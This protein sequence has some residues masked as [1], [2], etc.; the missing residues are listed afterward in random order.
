MEEKHTVAQALPSRLDTLLQ[1]K[2]DIGALLPIIYHIGKNE[3]WEYILELGTGYGRSTSV[4]AEIIPDGGFLITVDQKFY[5]KYVSPIK[6]IKYTLAVL[7][8]DD[9]RVKDF[10]KKL[11]IDKIDCL[12]IDADHRANAM[13]RDFDTYKDLVKDWG[14]I[15]FHDVCLM[16]EEC[17]GPNYWFDEPFNG[18]EKLTLS[19]SNGLG[20][21]RK[22]PNGN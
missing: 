17:E 22:I 11:S 21:L 4:L 10:I 8:E 14:Y 18:Y 13:K 2:S 6:N 9:Q 19:I 7:G 20:I 16:G 1:E 3:K 15:L 5:I 12:F